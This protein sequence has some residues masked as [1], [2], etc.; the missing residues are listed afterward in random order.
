MLTIS[1]VLYHTEDK[2]VNNVVSCIEKTNCV[3][4]VFLID[5]SPD[6]KNKIIDSLPSYFEYIK[7]TNTGYG[8]SHNIAIRKAIEIGA[9]YHLVLNP[10]ISFN[11]SVLPEIIDYMEKHDDVVYLMPNVISPKGKRQSLCK[12]LPTPIVMILRRFF[13]HSKATKQQNDKYLLKHSGYNKIMNPP[14]LSGCFMFLRVNTLKQNDLLFDERFFMYFEDFDLIRRLHRVGKTIFF[15]NVSIIHNHAKESYKNTKM[16]KIH[17]KS[18]IQYFN[19]YG[20][21]F[22]RE[23]RLMNKQILKEIE[24]LNNEGR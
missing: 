21:F 11:E 18:A 3:N 22:D 10:D 15:P 2:L 14:C 9:D 17:I 8:S 20:W 24:E 12:L 6:K 19:K 7:H 16:L 1:I 4:K 5:N 13:Q 23:R